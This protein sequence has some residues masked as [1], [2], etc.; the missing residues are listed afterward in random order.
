MGRTVTALLS[1]ALGGYDSEA[2][3]FEAQVRDEK[4][5]ELSLKLAATAFPVFKKQVRKGNFQGTFRELSGN[6]QGTCLSLKLAATA[7]PVFKKQAREL[8]RNFQGLVGNLQLHAGNFQG[9]FRELLG[10][11]R[12]H[13]RNFQG[14]YGTC[15]SLK[16]AATAFPVFKN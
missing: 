16:L 5:S 8:F 11:G 7:C 1:K 6:F 15:L 2:R 4:R 10:T 12:E 13:S 9:T 3:F 14:T